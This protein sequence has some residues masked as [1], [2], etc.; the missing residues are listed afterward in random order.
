MSRVSVSCGDDICIAPTFSAATNN[1]ASATGHFC[2]TT[3]AAPACG[4]EKPTCASVLPGANGPV[5]VRM[6]PRTDADG[7]DPCIIDTPDAPVGS[8]MRMGP[9]MS[10]GVRA[11]LT[12]SS[13]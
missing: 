2:S 6:S 4:S 8:S 11:L 5:M 13:R 3:V 12:T 1:C 9:P 10:I 7:D